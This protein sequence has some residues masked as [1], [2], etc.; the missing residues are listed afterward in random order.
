VVD[1]TNTFVYALD[2][3]S[4]QLSE[5]RLNAANGGLTAL[6][7]AVLSTGIHPVSLAIHPDGKFLYVIN[8]ASNTISGY[9]LEPQSGKLTPI[10]P[11]ATSAQPYGLAVK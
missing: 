7:P 11:L 6:N 5:Y 8:S 2:Q 10:T 4:N 1:N 3:G 9:S